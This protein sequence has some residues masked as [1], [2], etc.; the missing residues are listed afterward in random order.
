MKYLRL[1]A[2]VAL[3]IIAWASLDLATS[4]RY[5]PNAFIYGLLWAFPLIALALLAKLRPRDS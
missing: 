4:G 3:I 5:K 2:G 1:A